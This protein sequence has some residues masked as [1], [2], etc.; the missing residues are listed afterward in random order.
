MN[1]ILKWYHT[2]NTQCISCKCISCA[3]QLLKRLCFLFV[4]FKTQINTERRF[5]FK[6]KNMSKTKSW[7]I[8]RKRR[9]MIYDQR[10]VINEYVGRRFR[11]ACVFTLF[12]F[13]SL[14]NQP[15]MWIQ[16][17][18]YITHTRSAFHAPHNCSNGYVFFKL[19]LL[20]Q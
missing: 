1:T 6:I 5:L 15:S 10:N 8:M 17:E 4:T 3:A 20:K 14:E 11:S 12:H 7:I 9:G 18:N 2:Y 13:T 16:S 19:L